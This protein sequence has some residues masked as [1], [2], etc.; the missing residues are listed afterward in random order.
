MRKTIITASSHR[1]NLASILLESNPVLSGTH[2]LPF[3]GYFYESIINSDVDLLLQYKTLQ[4]LKLQKL[5]Q[6]VTFPKTV[7]DFNQLVE[8]LNA[9]GLS[10]DD[11]PLD[12]VYD[13]DIKLILT[14]LQRPLINN[15]E[16]TNYLDEGLK[17]HEY[18]LLQSLNCTALDLPQ[19][20]TPLSVQYKSALNFRQEVEG[21]IQYILENDLKDVGVVIP[22][23]KMNIHFIYSALK[24]YGLEV[25]NTQPFDLIKKQ[26]LALL[27]YI[28]YPSTR[29]IIDILQSNLFKLK[30][31]DSLIYYIQHFDL[32][33][34]TILTSF[35]QFDA[36]N[37]ISFARDLTYI[38]SIIQEDVS[39]L[40]E[41]L[42]ALRG[43]T[44][45]DQVLIAL[46]YIKDFDAQNSR[47][48][49]N[50]LQN[51]YPYIKEDVLTFI[52]D[53]IGNL[54]GQST[55][56]STIQIYDLNDLPI[57]P[58]ETL[59]ALGLS[60]KTL[61]G[62]KGQ[63]GILDEA[64]LSRI[65]DYPSQMDRNNYALN[66]KLRLFSKAKHLILSYHLIN[67]EGKSQEPSFNVENFTKSY[68]INR[69]TAWRIIENDPF[70]E[71][72]KKLSSEVAKQLY[73]KDGRIR[74][75][76]SS[77]EKYIKD[78]YQYFI[79]EGLKLKKP[80][81]FSF[82]ARVLGILMHEVLE[83]KIENP[84][85][86]YEDV[87]SQY[88]PFFSTHNHM[89]DHLINMNKETVL[90]HVEHL[91]NML[92]G[93][94]FRL[95]SQ[96]KSLF[97]NKTFNGYSMRG[98]VDRIDVITK[99]DKQSLMVID[100]KSSEHNLSASSIL[101][102]EQIQLL[103]Y[104][105]LL[106]NIMNVDI[107]GVY[108]YAVQRKRTAEKEYAYKA[109]RGVDHPLNFTD[110]DYL[111]QF[112]FNGWNF[113]DPEYYNVNPEI[114]KSSKHFTTNDFKTE[115][116]SIFDLETTQNF[117]RVLLQKI[118]K[119]IL[120]GIIDKDDLTLEFKQKPIIKIED[121][122]IWEEKE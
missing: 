83:K 10:V 75:S 43:I 66:Q 57:Q 3:K 89:I 78:P 116:G 101:K 64:Y 44:L 39:I 105:L 65:K 111:E 42:L 2:I 31:T 27:A 1:Q 90:F 50:Y 106:S 91:E 62:I 74:A 32:D 4:T 109:S 60:A 24:R 20:T 77:L 47:P 19:T 71:E 80:F 63:T 86:T 37:D 103:N 28:Q 96:E 29:N 7:H 92:K 69:P 18:K 102:G 33:V 22:N 13:H 41:K 49:H 88:R 56:L 97:D 117:M 99:E 61:P 9:Y 16:A 98:Y 107:F 58:L 87:L 122:K 110:E 119:N 14:V 26:Y 48:I 17:H 38:Q 54:S 21:A 15:K 104:A 59:I 82:D 36:D 53:A 11:L 79:E 68:N 118:R 113:T 100:Y 95:Y 93:S 67:F 12:N 51:I 25:D 6:L 35:N 85:I 114:F 70:M 52:I 112:V 76:A 121:T 55:N 23:K 34:E 81:D 72:T 5:S 8:R 46:D 30:H 40:Q 84:T 73:L 45:Q 120:N 108:Y 94:D 115:K